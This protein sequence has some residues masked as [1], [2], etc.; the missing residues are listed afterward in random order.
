M[1]DPIDI[2]S[3]MHTMT[4]NPPDDNWYMDAG[5]TSH[6]MTTQGLPNEDTTHEMQQHGEL[7]PITTS[8]L[9]QIQPLGWHLEEIHVTWAHLEKKQTR[10][11]LYT[12]SFKEIVHT[13]PGDGVAS[14]NRK[15]FW[16]RFSEIRIKEIE[17]PE[18]LNFEEFGAIHEGMALQNLNQFCHV[19][20]EQ[21]D[22]HFTSQA[23]NRLFRIKK[24]VVREYV[25]EFLSSF[26]FRNHIEELD[27]VDTMV[28]QLGGEGGA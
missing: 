5:A 17:C 22:R 23:W 8:M 15:E 6:M 7:Y 16:K 3:V 18:G 4:L 26:T 1:Y 12:K 11:Q 21:D 25:M 14:Y 19:S 27:V 9:Q 28:F 13:E 10:L 20:Y 24:Q 2:E